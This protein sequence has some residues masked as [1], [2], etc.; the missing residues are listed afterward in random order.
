MLLSKILRKIKSI[1]QIL[2]FLLSILRSGGFSKFE[3]LY[4]NRSDLLKNKKILITGGASGIGLA[5]AK[6]FSNDG[7]TVLITGRNID[8]FIAIEGNLKNIISNL[9]S[10]ISEKLTI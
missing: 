1:P 3:I 7:A 8:K 9:L 10:G 4:T 5:M 2:F 6:K